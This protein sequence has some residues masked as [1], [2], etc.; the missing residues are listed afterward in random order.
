MFDGTS[1]RFEVLSRTDTVLVL[2][3]TKEKNVLLAAERQP[4]VGERLHTIG[5]RIENGESPEAAAGRELAEESGYTAQRL[6]PWTAWQPLSK[7][8][9]AVYIYWAGGLSEPAG[10]SL[11]AG[12]Q[13]RLVPVPADDLLDFQ[14]VG[15]IQDAELMYQ[16]G[17]AGILPS[18]RE[19]MLDAFER[20]WMP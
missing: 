18:E 4:G 10:T 7:I 20:A 2:P 9:W 12:E 14:G 15:N 3:V 5:G 1:R 17:R 13:I 6:V 16:L 8:D 19:A 11:D